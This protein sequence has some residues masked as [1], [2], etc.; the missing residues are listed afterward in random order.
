MSMI[1]DITSA[2]PPHKRTQRKGRG[3][4]SNRGKTCGRGG[5]G[6][7]A[8]QGSPH[9]VPGHEGGQTKLFQRF[10]KRG[11]SNADFARRFYTVNVSDLDRFESGSIVDPSALI[12]AGLVP[13]ERQPV[14][15]LGDGELKKKLTVVAGWYSKTAYDK[16]TGVGGAAQDLKG[17]MFEF[18]KPKK[19]FIP[20]EPVRKPKKAEAAEE[21]AEAT[22]SEAKAESPKTD[23]PK[24]E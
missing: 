23:A 15:I 24:S 11:F 17:Q 16:I 10:P 21:G 9:W 13:D 2:V 18:P 5:K 14:K 8:R 6:S 22:R 4:S 1:H 3:R 7:S 19:K 20:R 12:E